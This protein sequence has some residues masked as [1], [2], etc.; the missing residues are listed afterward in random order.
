MH[1]V[2]HERMA[3]AK[4]VEYVKSSFSNSVIKMLVIYQKRAIS[5]TRFCNW[6]GEFVITRLV[7]IMLGDFKI[8]VLGKPVATLSSGFTNFF[9]IVKEPFHLSGSLVDHV[10]ISQDLLRNLNAEIKNFDV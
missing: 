2:C 4:Y 9:Q 3:G 10:Y 1:L 6:V 7:A 5:F 8:N